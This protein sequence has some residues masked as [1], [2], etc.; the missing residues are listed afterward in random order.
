MQGCSR[1][2]A[3]ASLPC[4]PAHPRRRLHRL[5]RGT[6][7]A[8]CL[9]ACGADRLAGTALVR[10]IASSAGVRS[11]S[12]TN[13][14]AT[15]PARTAARHSSGVRSD[16]GTAASAR[17]FGH[18]ASRQI[19]GARSGPGAD[20]KR[21][22]HIPDLCAVPLDSLTATA[23]VRRG[24]GT[25]C[26]ARQRHRTASAQSAGEFRASGRCFSAPPYCWTAQ[27]HKR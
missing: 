18:T 24:S 25:K 3:A 22:Q 11:A 17:P 14:R 5:F 13:C 10:A 7:L 15:L 21:L 4:V 16:S 9:A 6:L 1:D 20:P 12:G 19:S 26:T 23:G 2:G 27:R 8:C